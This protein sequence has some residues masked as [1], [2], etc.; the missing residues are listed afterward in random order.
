M[1]EMPFGPLV[2]DTQLVMTM[3]MISPNARV[4]MAR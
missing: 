3:R 4:T 1:P 2:S